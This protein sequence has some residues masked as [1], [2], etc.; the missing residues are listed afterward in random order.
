[1][2]ES[3][4][5]IALLSEVLVGTICNLPAG[6]VVRAFLKASSSVSPPVESEVM[7]IALTARAE[8]C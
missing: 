4:F 6:Q 7:D 2:R 3:C 8:E 1:M 5:I